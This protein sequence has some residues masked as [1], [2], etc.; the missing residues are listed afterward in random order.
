[1]LNIKEIFKTKQRTISFELFPPKT[2]EGE[3]KLFAT[4][5]QLASLKPDFFSCTYGAGG[6]SR[7]KTLDIVSHIQN[8]HHIAAMAHLTCVQHTQEEIK[9][10]LN[11][12][13][14]RQ[15]S[16]ILALRGDPPKDNPHYQLTKE[17]F[18]HSSDLIHFIRNYLG[19]EITIGAAGFPEGHVLAPNKEFD[20][21]ILKKKIDSGA[22]FIITQL[23]FNNQD[24]F[25]YLS[26]LKKL[27][28]NARIIPGILPI[29]DYNALVRFCALCGAVIPQNIHDT[30]RPIAD[31]PVAT[32]QAGIDFAVKQC[33][34][35]LD[36]GAP[37]LHFY[38]L[39]KVSPTNI[40]LKNIRL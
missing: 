36:R 18:E 20:A 11:D 16:N 33:Q 28:I 25:D 1:M 10:I 30:F 19:N 32:A 7:G 27:G 37:G 34:D 13:K 29:T 23:F 2:P 6:S 14:Q 5:E 22:D 21:G 4:I 26:R 35:L 39:N 24:Y 40:I 3:I 38:T 17:N 15:I 31:N 9:N 12:I 8:K